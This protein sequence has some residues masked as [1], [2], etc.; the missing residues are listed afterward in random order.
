MYA[1]I[2]ESNKT[3]ASL[4]HNTQ[5]IKE[6]N[7]LFYFIFRQRRRE[8]ER[9]RETSMCGCLLCTPHWGPGPQPRHVPWP[10]IKPVTLWFTGQHSIHW[11]TPARAK[12]FKNTKI[13]SKIFCIKS[14][15]ENLLSARHCPPWWG[16]R[17]WTRQ[18]SCSLVGDPTGN[19]YRSTC[20]TAIGYVLEREVWGDRRACNGDLPQSGVSKAF[21]RKWN[22]N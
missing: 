14:T 20:L 18:S 11:A 21:L 5:N 16:P 17:K 9:A 2:K 1:W 10:G 19:S 4:I 15:F 6:L 8:G 13:S 7:L 3:W 12:S 22:I